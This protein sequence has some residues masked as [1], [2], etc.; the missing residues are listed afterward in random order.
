M[1]LHLLIFEFTTQS[2]NVKYTVLRNIK[3]VT[4][5]IGN[6]LITDD[7]NAVYKMV[8]I[9]ILN[10]I[11]LNDFLIKRLNVGG[12]KLLIRGFYPW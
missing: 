7:S 3:N 8:Q 1:V 4:R 5:L 9:K 12:R 2:Q 11:V 10:T 6:S